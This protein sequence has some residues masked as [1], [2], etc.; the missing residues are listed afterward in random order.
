MVSANTL[1]VG[2]TRRPD[3]QP[4]AG[5]GISSHGARGGGGQTEFEASLGNV[6]HS[7]EETGLHLSNGAALCLQANSG[8]LGVFLR[9]KCNRGHLVLRN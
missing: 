8:L 9:N 3:H 7:R 1:S 4:S 2:V 5:A 6:Q